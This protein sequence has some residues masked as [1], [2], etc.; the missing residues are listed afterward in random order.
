MSPENFQPES[1]HLRN[2]AKEV[3]LSN[4]SRRFYEKDPELRLNKILASLEKTEIES[5]PDTW[6]S[7]LRRLDDDSN[8]IT[9]G[10]QKIPDP[11]A[12]KFGVQNS[13][14][15]EQFVYKLSHEASHAFQ[16]ETG[17]ESAL[18]KFLSGSNEI[19]KKYNPY[20]EL[21][22]QITGIGR[23]TGLSTLQIYQDQN[24]HDPTDLD[25]QVLE[26]ITELSC[27]YML[28][29]EVFLAWLDNS[30]TPLND[31]QRQFISTKIIEILGI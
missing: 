5:N 25:Y 30:P 20:L 26:D 19:D 24:T 13:T 12:E 3:N 31:S 10:L 29:D 6:I 2:I 4:V 16:R 8:I 9:I 18:L 17:Y 14:K 28:D 21:Y 23:I 27:A 15:E 22:A 1:V 7:R 11:I